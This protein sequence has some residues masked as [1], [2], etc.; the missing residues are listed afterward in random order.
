MKVIFLDIDGVLN[1]VCAE[2][3]E[4]GGCIG[5][6]DEPLA[7]LADLVQRT[8]AEIVLISS[9][10]TRWE[11]GEQC[12]R[13]GQYLNE[14]L[15]SVGLSI[16]DKTIDNHDDRGHGIAKWLD[17]HP[18]VESWLVLDD[19]IF[20]DYDEEFIRPCLM[21]T[22]FYT[23]GLRKEMLPICLEILNGGM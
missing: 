11:M 15:A 17:A 13:M 21:Q 6:A 5:I 3:R 9:W 14:R 18:E 10:K 22:N 7:V 19:D 20:P 2:A 23:G 4:P 1:Y 8:N 16:I 12:H